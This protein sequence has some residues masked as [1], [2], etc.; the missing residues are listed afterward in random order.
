MSSCKE[1]LICLGYLI[2]VLSLLAGAIT[3]F[4]FGIIYLIED[5]EISNECKGSNLWEYVLVSLILST[6]NMSIKSENQSNELISIIIV[7]IGIINLCL[8]IWGSIELWDY[9]Y[10]C[11]KL[12]N[13]NLWKVGLAGFILQVVTSII[14]VIF[15]PIL[16]CFIEYSESINKNHNSEVKENNLNLKINTNV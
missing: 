11:D 14:C 8:I 15:A 12:F 1:C 6:G 13:S 10:S 7:V 3:Y 4:V 16:L 2:V 5:Y 9:S